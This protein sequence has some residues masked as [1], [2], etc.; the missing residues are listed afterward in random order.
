MERLIEKLSDAGLLIE[1]SLWK[2]IFCSPEAEGLLKNPDKF[3]LITVI[4]TDSNL[5]LAREILKTNPKSSISVVDNVLC[6]DLTDALKPQD[7]IISKHSIHQVDSSAFVTH[8]ASALKDGGL[9]FASAPFFADKITSLKLHQDKCQ[10]FQGGI[11]LVREE[12]LPVFGGTVFVFVKGT[13][14]RELAQG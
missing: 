3:P 14:S 5:S 12:P 4:G 6:A 8:V 13:A 10:L 9:F 2:R 1:R 7:M 11:T